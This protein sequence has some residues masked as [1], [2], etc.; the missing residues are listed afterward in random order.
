MTSRFLSLFIA[1]TCCL[2]IFAKPGFVTVS[3]GQF[4]IDDKPYKYIGTNFW[5]GAILASEGEGGNR[6]RLH[7]ELDSLQS[8][9]IDNLRILVG[10]DGDRII[11]SQIEPKLQTAPGVYNE[12]LLNG[13]DYLLAEL[14]KRG[15]HAVLYLGNAWE[16]SGG[17]GTYLEWAGNGEAPVPS[18]DGYD[19]FK[20][21]VSRFSIDEKAKEMYASHVRNIV[22]RTNSLTGL[23]YSESPAIMSWQIANEPRCFADENKEPFAKWII[24][25]AEL[26]KSIDPNHLVSTGNEGSQGCEGD[27]NLWSKIHNNDSID[28]A[29]I[30]IWPYNWQW[31]SADSVEADVDN[32]I[33]LTGKYITDHRALTGKPLVAEEFGFPRDGMAI[34]LSS[35]TTARD[36]YF[37]YIFDVVGST[38]MLNG[39]NFWGWGGNA[40]PLHRVWQKGDPYSGDPAQEDQGLNS[41]FS[42]DRSTIEL[43]R[44]ANEMIK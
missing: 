24:D 17:F 4:M 12:T 42:T 41:V 13:L 15:M 19:I 35:P 5:Y 23:P 20:D 21:F 30:H 18:R 25:T 34:A 2:S 44:K 3:E 9:G 16:W 29:T 40:E 31:I 39:L 26:I 27:I 37:S 33:E 22:G 10:G 38:G 1:L 6:Q 32:A 43:I 7:T 36:K 14:E 28:Y 8:I 11:E